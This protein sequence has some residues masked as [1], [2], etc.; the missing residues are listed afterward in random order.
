MVVIDTDVQ[1]EYIRTNGVTLHIVQAG[2]EDGPLLLLL[3]GFPEFWYGWR[4]QISFLAEA[5]YR[6]WAPDQRGYNLSQK[7]P[8]IA[9]Y[10]LDELAADIVGLIDAAGR[11]TAHVVGHD[12]G[13]AVAWWLAN[14]YPQRLESLVVLNTPHHAALNRYLRRNL[15]QW[16]RS[17]YILFFQAPW[18]PERLLHAGNWRALARLMRA[19][20]RPGTFSES[21][22]E[23]YRRA[24]SQPGAITAM[25]N[26]Y[27]A[28]RQV[29]PQRLPD[30]RI[31]VPT[32][33]I[34]G[35]REVAF[36]GELAGL[37]IELC[38]DGRLV[39]FEQATHWVQHEEPDR[40]NRLLQDFIR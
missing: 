40:V 19:S 26:W 3:H 36:S 1:H 14:K 13:G 6:V 31:T 21:E 34:W 17:L 2:P 37:S 27:R 8:A 15:D 5:G 16:L 9:A 20:S 30:P 7:P 32:L 29:R 28:I 11:Q 10:N 12:W 25:L 33:L 39:R 24:W 22:M 23:A 4:H 38:D 18:L 35:E